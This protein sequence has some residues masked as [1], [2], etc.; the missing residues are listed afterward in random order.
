MLRWLNTSFALLAEASLFGDEFAKYQ[1]YS[2][3]IKTQ[4]KRG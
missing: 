4:Q 1:Q 3:R 2:V